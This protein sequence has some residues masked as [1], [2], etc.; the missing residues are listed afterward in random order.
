ML[1]ETKTSTD[2]HVNKGQ[3]CFNKMWSSS[4][5]LYPSIEKNRNVLHLNETVVGFLSCP[6]NAP[7]PGQ[8]SNLML[9]N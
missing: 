7:F 6:A 4:W 2:H 8:T 1:R 5:E 3:F 9:P